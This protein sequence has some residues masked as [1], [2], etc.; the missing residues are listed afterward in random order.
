MAEFGLI[1]EGITDQI[2][3][4][5]I[6]ISHFNNPDLLVSYLQPLRDAT[7]DSI[8][9]TSGNWHKVLE[10]CGSTVFQESFQRLDYIIIQIDS[11]IF[12]SGEVPEKYRNII[13]SNDE[14]ETIIKKI[15]TI[16]IDSI[17]ED[18][19]NRFEERI[20]FAIS[21][22]SIECWL[23]PIYYSTQKAKAGKVTGC[24]ETLNK[25]LQQQENFYI[26]EKKP[27]YYRKIARKFLK[28]KP[29]EFSSC[30]KMNPSLNFF[31]SSLAPLTS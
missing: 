19:Y 22:H 15:Q 27:E 16:I 21:V 8:A 17:G 20:I 13:H 26:D 11:D 29:K 31:I 7:S 3:V 10:Y 28:M 9:T 18:H 14:F 5:N 6:L 25:A 4:E 12:M 1:G 30:V 23:L 24:L 2:V